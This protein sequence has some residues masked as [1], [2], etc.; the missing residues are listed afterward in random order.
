MKDA[1]NSSKEL[2]S[3]CCYCGVGCGVVIEKQ[4]DGTIRVRGDESHPSNKG[5]LCSK[6][7]NLHH[8]VNDQSDRL[9]FPQMRYHKDMP[10][11][12]VDWDTA[13]ERTAAVFK[14]FIKKYGPNSVA[15]YASGQFLTEEYYVLNKLVKGFIGTNNIDTNSRLCMSSAVAAYKMT[16]GEDSVPVCYDDIELSDCILVAGANP[17]WCHPIIWRRVEKHKANNPAVKIIV[18]DPRVTDS[19]AIADLHLQIQPGTDVTLFHV[20]AKLLIEAGKVDWNFIESHTDGFEELRD[21]VL[22]ISVSEASDICGI[23]EDYIY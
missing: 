20:I 13:L 12:R 5:L 18:I 16:L 17:A 4:S 11:Q 9:L 23:S 6:G 15:F 14:T 1:K 8:T 21:L 7:M 3:T 2:K 10:L 19:C 22:T